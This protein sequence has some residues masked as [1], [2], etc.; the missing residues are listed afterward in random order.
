MKVISFY[1]EPEPNSTYYTRYAKRF[2]EACERLN[3]DYHVEK[4]QGKGNYFKNCKMKPSF[5][6]SCVNKFNT[7]VLW[8]DIDSDIKSVP[9]I[10]TSLDFAAVEKTN[11]A[12]PIYAH[13]LFFNTTQNGLRL[14]NT[15]K[16]IC[17]NDDNATNG[18]HPILTVLMKKFT[19]I[20][21]GYIEDFTKFN[22]TPR[23][24][25]KSKKYVDPKKTH[26]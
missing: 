7:P 20:S 25:I 24:E 22:L 19:D 10:D 6:Q 15:W 9:V 12:H 11:C 13:C 1:S 3:I 2:I 26:Q 4:L 17:D 5:I 23:S 14:L 8:I 21:F 16:E 18:D